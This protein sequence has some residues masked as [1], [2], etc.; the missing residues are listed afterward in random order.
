MKTGISSL[1]SLAKIQLKFDFRTSL[2]VSSSVCSLWVLPHLLCVCCMC[3]ICSCCLS[4][5]PVLHLC[6]S[7]TTGFPLP[8]L[9]STEDT[10]WERNKRF[11]AE[12]FGRVLQGRMLLSWHNSP[13]RTLKTT[14]MLSTAS[15]C[16]F[17]HLFGIG[18]LSN[19]W[20]LLAKDYHNTYICYSVLG[21]GRFH[22]LK[23]KLCI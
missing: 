11:R 9:P 23:L 4:V 18:L 2:P 10:V 1:I 7:L 3:L 19:C 17:Q 21:H 8:S 20:L 15:T 14:Q 5:V 22:N 6:L 13:R 16:R 12:L